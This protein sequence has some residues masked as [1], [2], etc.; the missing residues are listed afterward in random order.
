MAYLDDILIFSASVDEHLRYLKLK[1]HGLKIKLS[2]CQFMKRETKYLGFI[3]DE[4]GVHPD[5]DKVEVIRA[6]PEP[7]TCRGKKISY[8]GLARNLIRH[9][10]S[11]NQD[12]QSYSTRT[13]FSEHQ[14]LGKLPNTVSLAGE[15]RPVQTSHWPFFNSNSNMDT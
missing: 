1:K 12:D 2:K 3:I 13:L 5:I 4:S 6:I 10:I 14:K 9:L 7:R 8:F 11:P 15:R